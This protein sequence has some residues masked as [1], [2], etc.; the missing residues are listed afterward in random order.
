[1]WPGSYWWRGIRRQRTGPEVKLLRCCP[2]GLLG[3]GKA[4]SSAA[5]CEPDLP[6]GFNRAGGEKQGNRECVCLSVWIH[7]CEH[8]FYFLDFHSRILCHRINR[9]FRFPSK[10]LF[11]IPSGSLSPDV[12]LHKLVEALL[13]IFRSNLRKSQTVPKDFFGSICFI[14]LGLFVRKDVFTYMLALLDVLIISY[15]QTLISCLRNICACT[16]R[17]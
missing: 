16:G 3:S 8:V 1:M 9:G 2:T 6:S 13:N 11:I 12:L 7:A 5:A 10:Y 14:E 15:W 17:I 4:N